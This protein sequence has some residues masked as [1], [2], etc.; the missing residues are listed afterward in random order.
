MINLGSSQQ[1]ET[2]FD[3]YTYAILFLH[4][5]HIQRELLQNRAFDGRETHVI[6]LGLELAATRKT[7]TSARKSPIGEKPPL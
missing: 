2:C 6:P 1:N 4:T 7:E 5:P 3:N